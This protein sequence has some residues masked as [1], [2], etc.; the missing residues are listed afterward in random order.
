LKCCEGYISHIEPEHSDLNGQ[1]L[2][3][4]EKH[5]ISQNQTNATVQF[6]DIVV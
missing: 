1:M 2:E 4:S 6:R 5:N 3:G